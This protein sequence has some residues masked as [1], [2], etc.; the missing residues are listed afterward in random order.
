MDTNHLFNMIK[1]FWFD[2]NSAQNKPLN[3]MKD[4]LSHLLDGMIGYRE[5]FV[6][7]NL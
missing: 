7:Q 2:S 3:V 4:F 1:N 5:G 6:N